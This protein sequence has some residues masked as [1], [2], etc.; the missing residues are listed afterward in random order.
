MYLIVDESWKMEEHESSIGM[1]LTLWRLTTTM[2]V[3]PH[4]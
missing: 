1:L 2:V 4:R 3:E